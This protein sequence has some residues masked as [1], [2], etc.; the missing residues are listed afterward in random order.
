MDHFSLMIRAEQRSTTG[1]EK[2]RGKERLD[3]HS[4]QYCHFLCHLENA[5][6]FDVL[7]TLCENSK[8][9]AAPVK[10]KDERQRRQSEKTQQFE[11]EQRE[12]RSCQ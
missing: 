2:K 6:T 7:K 9:E 4:V 5:D 11:N 8:V 12:A 10:I 1:G 3:D